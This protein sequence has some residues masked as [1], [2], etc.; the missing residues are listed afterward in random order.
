[1][2][3]R[4]PK[5]I[6]LSNAAVLSD[7]GRRS[8]RFSVRVGCAG[9]NIPREFAAQFTPEGSHLQRYS[10]TFNCCEIN[11]SFYRSHREQTWERWAESVPVA[12]RFSVKLPRT[13]THEEKLNCDREK[14]SSF[15][16]EISCL[17]NKLGPV[18]IQLPPSLVF[19]KARAT[20]FLSMLRERYAGEVVWEPRHSSWFTDRV[21]ELLKEFRV[22]RVAADPAC[23][24]NASQPGGAPTLVYFRLHGSP[25]TYYSAYA[26]SFLKGFSTELAN[27]AAKSQ[28]WCVFDNTAL[29]AAVQNA[30]ELT[31]RLKGV[32]PR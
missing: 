27:F 16:R 9:W 4:A 6:D 12:F 22:S 1:L 21:E 10:Q 3:R 18:L 28:V 32:Q 19:E 7:E 13:I 20:R 31:S 30:L 25:R 14:L 15:I 5:V 8:S 2:I 26:S 29:G 24:P 23:V 11:S 17:H